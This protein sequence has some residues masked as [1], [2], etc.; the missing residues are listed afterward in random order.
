MRTDTPWRVH[1]DL[2]WL[3]QLA[4]HRL[5]RVLVIN[6]AGELRGLITVKDMMKARITSYNVCY[7]KLLRV[8][9]VLAVASR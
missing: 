4:G 9:P 5:E 2:H 3:E 8:P 1:S 7:T 6:S